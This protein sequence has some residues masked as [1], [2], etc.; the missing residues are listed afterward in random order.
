MTRSAV[1]YVYILF[2]FAG[3]PRYVGK[4]KGNRWLEHEQRRDVRYNPFLRSLIKNARADGKE[5]PKIKIRD[6]LREDAAFALEIA[7]IKAIGR[8]DLGTGPLTNLHDGG[9]GLA[10]I[11]RAVAS[12]DTRAKQSAAKKGKK[13]T[14]AHKAKIGAGVR[15]TIAARDPERRNEVG[16]KIS[17]AVKGKQKSRGWWS[18][19]E[20]REKQRQNNHG[21]RTPR[22]PE[23]R[24]RISASVKATMTPERLEIS[25]EALVRYYSTDEGRKQRGRTA[26]LGATARWGTRTI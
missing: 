11:R 19:L 12:D 20:G 16:A 7:L 8:R 26:I 13:L 15:V 2:D 24:A 4:G 1:F 25:R 21:N 22:S 10:G 17:A 18:T 23:M 6:G 14:A 5:L 9:V 3:V